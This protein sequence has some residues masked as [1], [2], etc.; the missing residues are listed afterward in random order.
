M[1]KKQGA[2]LALWQATTEEG[3]K[4][5]NGRVESKEVKG[6]SSGAVLSSGLVAPPS[7]SPHPPVSASAVNSLE[8]S[9]MS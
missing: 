9:T 6:F 1:Y 5:W 2:L 3:I 8:N 4:D 7:S